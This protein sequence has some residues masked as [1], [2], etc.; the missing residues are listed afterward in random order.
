MNLLTVKAAERACVSESLVYEWCAA[1]ALPHLRL[2]KPGKRGCIRIVPEE[3][4]EFLDGCHVDGPPDDD[5]E[6]PPL[7]HLR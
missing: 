6:E 2:G 4:D 5:D 7:K 3:F 1:G